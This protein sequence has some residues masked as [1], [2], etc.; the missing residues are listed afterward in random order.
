LLR[1]IDNTIHLNWSKFAAEFFPRI[2]LNS[3]I[4]MPRSTFGIQ[5]IVLVG[6]SEKSKSWN[7][8]LWI[9]SSFR[10]HSEAIFLTL[11]C[12]S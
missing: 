11:Q 9:F 6:Q 8:T 4:V 7:Q 5:W 2:I 3:L 1:K 12:L 10:Q